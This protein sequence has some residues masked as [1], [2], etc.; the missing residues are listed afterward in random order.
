MSKL[1]SF[2]KIERE[3]QNGN[4]HLSKTKIYII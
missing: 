1:I 3:L 2:K 4:Y